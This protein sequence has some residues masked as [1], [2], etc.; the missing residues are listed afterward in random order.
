MS[1]EDLDYFIRILNRMDGVATI[2]IGLCEFTASEIGEIADQAKEYRGMA[3]ALKEAKLQIEYLHE[4][5]GET[6]SGN[7]VL[8]KINRVLDNT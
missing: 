7:A 1:D 8:A 5:F 4:K 6:G 3:L 2:R